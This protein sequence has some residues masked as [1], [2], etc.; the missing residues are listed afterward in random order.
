[1]NVNVPLFLQILDIPSEFSKVT[2][3]EIMLSRTIT[4]L[5]EAE[6]IAENE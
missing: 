5:N 3:G 1:M 2:G 6:N 4:P